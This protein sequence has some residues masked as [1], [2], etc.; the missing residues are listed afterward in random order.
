MAFFSTFE[1]MMAFRYLRARRKEGFIS[2]I[3]GFSFAGIALGVATLIVVMAVMNG[4]RQ[5]LLSRVLGVDGHV[6]VYAEN[7]S[8]RNY[9]ELAERVRG[10]EHVVRVV[11]QVEGQVMAMA[12][13]KTAGVAVRG[14]RPDDLNASKLIVDNIVSG[15]VDAFGKTK[16]GVVVGYRLSR[17][18]GISPG[19]HITLVSP[20]GRFTVVG[21]VPRMKAYEV[22]ATFEVGMYE[23]DSAMIYMPMDAAQTYFEFGEAVSSIEA[24]LDHPDFAPDVAAQ[25]GEKLGSGYQVYDWQRSH[26][27]FFNALK[28]ERNVMFLI[29]TLIIVIA[30][31]NIISGL[32]MLV[33]DKSRDIAILRT[34]GATRGAVMRIFFLTGASIGMTGTLAGFALGVAFSLNIESIRQWLQGLTGTDLFAAEIYFLSTLPA[35]VEVDDVASVVLMALAL[36]FLATIYPA[37]RAARLD[38][39]EA[40]RY[41]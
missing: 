7:T 33:K 10:M 39:V 18:L 15:T 25:L 27:Q 41:E 11:P 5:E 37:W 21:A 19:D 3:T 2:I 23:Y 20:K 40:L 9:D 14:V 28:V 24:M 12:G 32:V 16:N 38:P 34:M 22:I 4:F 29:L 35:K 36:S 26:A 1:R 30:A 17:Q 31:F 6:V 13:Q 8:L